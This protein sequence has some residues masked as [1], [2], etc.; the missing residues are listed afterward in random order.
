MKIIA[1]L[2][3]QKIER[4]PSFEIVDLQAVYSPDPA[5][6][7]YTF[8]KAT[9]VAAVRMQ[10]DNPAALGAFEPGREYKVGFIRCKPKT[11]DGAEATPDR[12]APCS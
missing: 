5:S 1:K 3:C 4:Y 11:D 2:C 6:E 12:P 7:N 10:I 9:P 8:A